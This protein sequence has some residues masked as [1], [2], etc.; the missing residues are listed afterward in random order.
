MLGFEHEMEGKVRDQLARTPA[1]P[2]PATQI[3]VLQNELGEGA[4]GEEDEIEAYRQEVQGSP[5]AG[6]DGE[7]SAEGGQQAGQA[8][9]GS[10]EGAVIRN[11]LDVCLEMPWN[12]TTRE[13]VS[14]DAARKVL[15]TTTSAWRRSRSGFWR[16]LPSGR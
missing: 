14:V 7:A 9:F 12:T 3:Q 8:A 5:A 11:Y 13:R 16:P 15:S 1:G 6:G 2:D 4:D 10:A